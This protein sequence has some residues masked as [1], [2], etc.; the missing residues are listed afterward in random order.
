MKIFLASSI[1]VI[2]LLFFSS[3]GADTAIEDFKQTASA[4]FLVYYDRGV[5]P[6]DAARVIKQA[7]DYYRRI[8]QEFY[9]IRDELWS[10]DKRAKI[11]I[12]QDN[13]RYKKLFV[14]Q[15]WSAACVDYRNKIIYTYDGQ[16]GFSKILAHELTHIIFRE[17]A[18]SAVLSLWL[19]EGMAT[20]IEDKYAGGH[21]ARYLK[22]I[23]QKIAGNNYIPLSELTGLSPEA[24]GCKDEDYVVLFYAQ[25]YSLVNFIIGKYGRHNFSRFIA[26]MS[27]GMPL[28]Q[29]LTKVY[30]DF[31][32][33]ERFERLWKNFY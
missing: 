32:D 19:D 21:Y 11:Y 31:R 8:T 28:E 13:D 14:C 24:L 30:I 23:R 9:L 33:F 1:S 16:A 5:S 22:I 27:K 4:H 26:H 6:T 15:S 29:A 18:R 20:Y 7:E 2:C 12:A 3:A 25:S 10:Q 17:Y